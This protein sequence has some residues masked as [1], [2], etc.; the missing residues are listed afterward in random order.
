[1]GVVMTGSG[2]LS[3][4]LGLALL[5]TAAGAAGAAEWRLQKYATD[6]FQ[7]EFSGPV[8]V[9]EQE[10]DAQTRSRIVRSTTYIQDGG[11]T[12]AYVA[13]AML[14]KSDINFD[15]ALKSVRDSCKSITTD[16]A[17][18][19]AEGRGRELRGANCGAG[20]AWRLDGRYFTKGNW[21]YQAFT[22][23]KMNGSDA[24]NE[25]AHH[26]VQSF[27]LIGN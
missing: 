6:G 7:A 9:A 16:V 11:N 10:L 8:E 25:A 5:L 13:I 23:V 22:Y 2:R 24:D 1:M 27:S 4:I 19:V 21:F 14:S 20:N 26:F 18:N 15:G 12:F 3:F 17:I